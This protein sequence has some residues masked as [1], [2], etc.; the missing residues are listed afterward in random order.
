LNGTIC[1]FV[2]Y[3]N[4]LGAFL[5]TD[6]GAKLHLK[7]SSITFN[8]NKVWHAGND[9]SGSGLDSDL[10]DGKH[11][12]DL[13]I[14]GRNYYSFNNTRTDSYIT[15]DSSIRGY[16]IRHT[17]TNSLGRIYKLGFNGGGDFT[18]SF[19]IKAESAITVNVNLCD[20][21]ANTNYGE[22]SN[23]QVTTDYVKHIYVFTNVSRFCDE[24]NSYN[25][26]LDI[27]YNGSSVVYVKN[28]KIER[29]TKA[30]DWS[31]SPFDIVE[32]SGNV[33]T[34]TKL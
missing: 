17:S 21:S 15:K 11:W 13:K 10:W 12:D 23:T 19:E 33:A 6:D 14:G 18:V 20:T 32:T 3:N 27:E 16:I 29:G 24:A 34:A 8:T 25:G 1:A 30:T 26:F 7:G 5:E 4:S 2:G 9:G 31:L 28:I 22:S